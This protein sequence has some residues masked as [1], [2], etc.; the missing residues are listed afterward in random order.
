MKAV[1]STALSDEGMQ[2]FYKIFV[3]QKLHRH[4]SPQ[5][6]AGYIRGLWDNL[7]LEARFRESNAGIVNL[8]V[9]RHLEVL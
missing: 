4:H 6:G 9:K 1:I 8:K 3:R 7:K 2:A 5:Q